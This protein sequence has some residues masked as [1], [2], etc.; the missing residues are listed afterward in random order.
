MCFVAERLPD[1]NAVA[2]VIDGYIRVVAHPESDDGTKRPAA[3]DLATVDDV[4]IH[5]EIFCP[6]DHR[7][8]VE[9]GREGIEETGIVVQ[10]GDRKRAA[11]RAVAAPR[12]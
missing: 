12:A 7:I 10:R 6:D 9:V 4:A 1:R 11:E 2:V 3:G 5:G 8:A